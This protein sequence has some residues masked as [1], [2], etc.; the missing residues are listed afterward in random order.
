MSK[1]IA[2]KV[3]RKTRRKLEGLAATKF[4][5]GIGKATIHVVRLGL[6][7]PAQT[8]TMDQNA[9]TSC[10]VNVEESLVAEITAFQGAKGIAKR[11]DATKLLIELGLSVIDATPPTA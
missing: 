4:D 11:T 2:G 10:S 1:K 8:N 5:G 3:S 6:A 7:A 9:E